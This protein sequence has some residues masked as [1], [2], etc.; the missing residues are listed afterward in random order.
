M[1]IC[2]T[3]PQ[4]VNMLYWVD[5]PALCQTED[6]SE[7]CCQECSIWLKGLDWSL[8][9]AWASPVRFQTVVFVTDECSPVAIFID[10]CLCRPWVSCLTRQG[11][12]TDTTETHFTNKL[13]A[14]NPN[15]VRICV[16]ITQ[17]LRVK[18]GHNFA[19]GPTAELSGHVQNCDLIG[20]L[21]LHSKQNDIHKISIMG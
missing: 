19:H 20:P 14:H 11:W 5:L 9:L 2:V 10:G 7:W 4:W 3:Q 18:S 8:Q 15:L 13:W 1:H 6:E 17:K 21:L 12:G 16:V